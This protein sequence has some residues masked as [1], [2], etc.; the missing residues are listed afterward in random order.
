[1]IEALVGLQAD[2]PDLEVSFT[3]PVLPTGLDANGL[4]L[5]R[6]AQ[7]DGVRIDV[8]N[9]MA[10]D[11]GAVVDNNGQMGLNAIQAAVATEGQPAASGSTPRLASRR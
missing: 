9:I 2:N 6:S 7:H 10:M 1:M 3:L 8:V 5:L 11:Y 4:N